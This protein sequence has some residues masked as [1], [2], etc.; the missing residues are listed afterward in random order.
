VEQPGH[1]HL[2]YPESV[3]EAGDVGQE[4]ID[5]VGP[6]PHSVRSAPA[7]DPLQRVGSL[8]TPPADFDSALLAFVSQP[9]AAQSEGQWASR[10]PPTTASHESS[11]G[12]VAV[13]LPPHIGSPRA[14]PPSSP[15]SIT[16]L[17]D[18][19][20]L[21]DDRSPRG[22][23]H[24]PPEETAPGGG[25]PV[26]TGFAV[27][28]SAAPEGE[29]AAAEAFSEPSGITFPQAHAAQEVEFEPGSAFRVSPFAAVPGQLAD[30]SSASAETGSAGSVENYSYGAAGDWDHPDLALDAAH[31]PRR[32]SRLE[33]SEPTLASWGEVSP[34][35][36]NAQVG[37]VIT[38]L[39]VARRFSLKCCWAST[40][41]KCHQI[42]P[43]V[44]ICQGLINTGL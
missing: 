44:V 1:E 15:I 20:T 41:S 17:A 16:E 29:A 8:G 39:P 33:D 10:V 28:V 24:A 12:P 40:E 18:A 30:S 14:P 27:E 7:S 32:E 42:F 2:V 25:A 13:K 22:A 37:T 34:G 23:E 3:E 9:P 26:L 43:F 4:E 36:P 11:E 35:H 19:G 38:L 5:S 21:T 31:A 6:L